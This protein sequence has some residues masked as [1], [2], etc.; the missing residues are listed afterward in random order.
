[1]DIKPHLFVKYIEE[2]RLAELARSESVLKCLSCF[3][4]AERCPRGVE[5]SALIEAVRLV[6]IRKQGGNRNIV[7]KIP[8]LTNNDDDIPQQLIV[9]ILRKYNR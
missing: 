6:N 8:G 1:M 4:C 2:G 5:P 7:D 3:A 9:S